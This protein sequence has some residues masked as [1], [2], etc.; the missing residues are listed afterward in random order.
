MKRTLIFLTI[1]L[2]F[3]ISCKKSSSNYD[4]SLYGIFYKD[5]QAGFSTIYTALY[6]VKNSQVISDASIFLNDQKLNYIHPFYVLE[7]P[8][9]ENKPYN[10]KLFYGD[11]SESIDF[12]T[13]YLPDTFIIIYPESQTI[14][15]YQDLIVKW[16]V[17][18]KYTQT[19]D[20]KFVVFFENK[21]KNPTL[22]YQ[23]DFLPKETDSIVIPG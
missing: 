12:K 2:V 7:Y 21:S 13:I 17:S 18:Q 22:V 4:I 8:Y 9:Y 14:S 20:Y 10:L 19:Y 1:F 3:F 15:L 16:K 23:T 11:I 6:D 5:S